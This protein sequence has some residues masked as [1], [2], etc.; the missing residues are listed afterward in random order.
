MKALR[1]KK[2]SAPS[3]N[4]GISPVEVG[5]VVNDVKYETTTS[6][7]KAGSDKPS[8]PPQFTGAK[9]TRVRETYGF[10]KKIPD[11]YTKTK[12]QNPYYSNNSRS[13]NTWKSC[14]GPNIGRKVDRPGWF[15]KP[16]SKRHKVLIMSYLRSKKKKSDP[17]ITCLS[18]CLIGVAFNSKWFYKDLC[19]YIRVCGQ[20]AIIILQPPLTLTLLVLRQLAYV[21]SCIGENAYKIMS[22]YIKYG[23]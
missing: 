23:C 12:I 18:Q 7:L 17:T 14:H 13:S 6:G 1:K 10:V 20:W 15:R 22:S 4:M 5:S 3:T 2:S 8:V 9:V 16:P 19:P 21:P 11:Y